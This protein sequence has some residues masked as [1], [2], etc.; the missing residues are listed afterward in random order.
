MCRTIRTER[1]LWMSRPH[2]DDTR[3]ETPE[4]GR[5]P[6]L[7]ADLLRPDAYDHAADDLRLHETHSSWVVLAG[8][9]AYKLKKPVDLGFL[10][11][12]TIDRRRSDCEEE[13]RLNRRFSPDVYLGI[14]EVA[15]LQGRF[16]VGGASGS[17][18]PAVWMRRLP[19]A[20]MLPGASAHDKVDCPPGP[21]YRTQ[22]GR[23]PRGGG[24]WPGHRRVRQPRDRGRNWDENFDQMAPFVGR[25][26][27]T[28]INEHIRAYVEAFLDERTALLEQRVARGQHT[29]W[30]W[31]PA[32]R[33]H[34]H[35]GWPDSTV[36]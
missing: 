24:D 33:E 8:P 7:I 13:L 18:E 28:R 22:A 19:E 6:Q 4:G 27:A 15:E 29:R 11:F 31:R 12:T 1:I 30:T 34:L 21:P 36:R 26:V 35:R 10:D 32:R 9:Y 2:V 16:H 20:G 17:G 5:Q 3:E 14:A 25:T 23:I